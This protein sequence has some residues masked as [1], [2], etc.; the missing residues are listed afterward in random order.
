MTICYIWI[1]K[2]RNF[3]NTGFNLSSQNKF[4]Y[5]HELKTIKKEVVNDL[6]KDF[7]GKNIKEVT[8]F[9]GKN[10]SGKS[11]AL[12]L[13][14][15]VLKNYKSTIN[16]NYLVIYEENGYLECRYNFSDDIAP[17]ANFDISIDHF[18][19]PLN[20]LKVVFFSNV[21]DDRRNNFGKEISDVSVNN[22]YRNTISR[23]RETSDFLKQLKLINS[24]TFKNLNIEYP[25]KVVISTRIFS[26]RMNSSMEQSLYRQNYNIY[27]EFKSFIGKRLTDSKTDKKFL[28]SVRFGFFFE[29]IEDYLRGNRYR[30]IRN[31][32]YYPDYDKFSDK[33]GTF[34]NDQFDL[35]TEEISENILYFIGEL[36]QPEI[37]NN[38]FT[39]DEVKSHHLKIEFLFKL[40]LLI[41][42]VPI[43]YY[44]EGLRTNSYEDFVFEYSSSKSSKIIND[45]T[46]LFDKENFFNINWIGISSGHKAYLNLF[47]TLFDELKFTKQPNLF[48][49]IDEGDL[50]L[51][52]KWQIEFFDRLI[53]VL[54]N[55][56]SGKIQLLLT[57]HSPFILS[58][59]PNQNI[60]ILHNTSGS[61]NGTDLNIK[62]FGGNLYDL[63]SEPFFLKEKKTSEF[64]YKQIKD[65]ILKLES[66]NTNYSKE[67]ILKLVNI[68]GDEIIS[69]RLKNILEKN[70]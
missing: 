59:L 10:G 56:Y 43:E 52:P 53:N 17:K 55:I 8:A 34:L 14:C 38:L 28:Y 39:P 21:F 22:K 42:E 7:F 61:L 65:L 68:I 30:Y 12:E 64:A 44:L 70:D 20:P 35:R 69:L 11:N 67:E 62:T 19:T 3:S 66:N 24:S 32:N 1:E 4:D 49:C 26:A 50:Y 36:F 40:K 13:I 57:S 54:P 51:H 31:N 16:T 18:E 46:K 58:D 25:N 5:N 45:F 9:V 48:L 41:V 63:Y 23:K 37:Q 33:L 15:K 6:P 29:Y 2:F 47:A 60:T 27:K